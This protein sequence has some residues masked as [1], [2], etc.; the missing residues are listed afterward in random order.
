[1]GTGQLLLLENSFGGQS[2][3]FL[4]H[5]SLKWCLG[6]SCLGQWY[7]GR[8]HLDIVLR[9][10]ADGSNLADEGGAG[11]PALGDTSANRFPHGGRI[12]SSVLNDLTDPVGKAPSGG[13]RLP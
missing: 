11:L 7:L 12:F 9:L 1:M 3:H 6:Q 13:N 4:K 2:E 10:P 8:D 5:D